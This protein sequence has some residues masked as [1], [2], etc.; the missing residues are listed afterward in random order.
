M[1]SQP[2]KAPPENQRLR[3]TNLGIKVGWLSGTALGSSLAAGE[4]L[5]HQL[6]EKMDVGQTFLYC[7]YFVTNIIV[8]AVL[9]GFFGT[10]V[11]LLLGV[12]LD[13]VRKR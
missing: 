2:Q 10:Y 11:G 4:L 1:N 12:V 8:A 9:G 13:A 7:G 5:L 3:W 6:P